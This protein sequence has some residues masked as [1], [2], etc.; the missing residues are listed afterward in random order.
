MLHV[1]AGQTDHLVDEHHRGPITVTGGDE[2]LN[3]IENRY[4]GEVRAAER[5]LV[6]DE[7]ADVR[8]EQGSVQGKT[9]ADRMP[10]QMHRLADHVYDRGHVLEIAL[11]GVVIAVRVALAAATPV[12]RVD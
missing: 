7:A 2:P 5:G 11:H 4:W 12:H 9:A 1:R 3:P 8:R 6:D 10:H